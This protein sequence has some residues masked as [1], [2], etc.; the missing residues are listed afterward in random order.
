MARVEAERLAR[1][2]YV[3]SV[4]IWLRI[5]PV[6]MDELEA[7]RGLYAVKPT[8]AEV[9][10]QL[11]SDGLAFRQMF[12][13]RSVLRRM[14]RLRRGLPEKPVKGVPFPPIVFDD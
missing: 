13:P 14:N 9:A 5:A 6:M 10:R 7:E 11:L 1:A 4:D 3:N 8:K 2:P 12:R